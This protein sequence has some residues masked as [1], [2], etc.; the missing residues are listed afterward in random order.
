[1]SDSSEGAKSGYITCKNCGE[2]KLNRARFCPHCG[3]T[4]QPEPETTPLQGFMKF[5]G[6]LIIIC[7]LL[8]PLGLLAICL[9]SDIVL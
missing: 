7:L 3:A 8:L 5:L 2:F 4:S 9:S 1:M 6:L